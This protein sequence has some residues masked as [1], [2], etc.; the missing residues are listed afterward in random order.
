MSIDHTLQSSGDQPGADVHATGRVEYGTDDIGGPT[1]HAHGLTDL[2][3]VKVAI[4]L[5]LMTG[6][7]VTLTYLHLPGDV[8]MAV[9]LV[10]MVLKFWTVVSYFMHLK[11][12]SKIFTRLFYMGLFLAVVVF[13][14]VLCTFQFFSPS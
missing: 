5:A 3:Y 7:E 2:G 6:A 8:F 4:I 14:A 9:L 1:D 11:F 13:A 12:D 10:L